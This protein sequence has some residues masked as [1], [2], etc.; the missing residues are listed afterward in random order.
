MLK[1][2]DYEAC[3]NLTCK[4]NSDPDTFAGFQAAMAKGG[5][6]FGDWL[7]SNGIPKSLADEVSSQTGD[8]LFKTVGAAICGRFW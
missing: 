8:E 6:A 1:S 3:I 5:A 4:M 7:H 2:S